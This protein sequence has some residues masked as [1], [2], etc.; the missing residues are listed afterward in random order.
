MIVSRID[1]AVSADGGRAVSLSGPWTL[2]AIAPQMAALESQLSEHAAD[3]SATWDGLAVEALDSAGAMLLWRAWGR[4]LPELLLARPEHLHVFD[5]I[6]AADR[7][8]P[9]AP[10]PASPFEGLIAVGSAALS[11]RRHLADFAVLVGRLALDLAH[12]ARH[13]SDLPRLEISANLFKSGVRAMPVT[14]LLGFL[15]GIVLSYLSSLQ[16]SRIGADIFIINILG[17]GI[18][19]E[20]G[21]VLVAVLVA[22][23]SGSAMTAQLGV[24]RVTEEIDALAAMGVPGSLRL[25]FPKVVALALA[26]PLLVL[27]TTAVALVGGMVSAQAQLDIGYGF[28]LD[29][30]P[31]VVPVA[32]LWI[33]LVKG[34]VFGIFVALIA[35]HFGLRVRPNTESLS[36]NTTASVVTSITV[37]ILIDAV[38]AIATRHIGLPYK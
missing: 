29:T 15:I 31:K 19:R 33:G 36:A 27:W 22:G 12:L 11:F 5:R 26:M 8:T 1:V 38:F 16:L 4:R 9:A 23:R 10:V 13:P 6:G 25:V 30:L 2:A 24:M 34:F 20:M 18:V 14:A 21:P 3:P 28:F 17:M 35:C 32:N 37:V 7:P